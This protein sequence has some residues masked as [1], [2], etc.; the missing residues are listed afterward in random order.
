MPTTTDI[1]LSLGYKLNDKSVAGLGA[2][3]KLG[4]GSIQ[5][6]RFT[7]QGVGLRS[8]IDWKA[9]FGSHRGRKEASLFVSGGYELNYNSAFKNLHQLDDLNAWQTA[10]LI[11]IS[12]RLKIKTKF[13]KET[14]FQLLYDMLHKN[15]TPVTQPVIFRFGYQIK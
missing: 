13:I 8:F 12:K 1:G 10:G 7:H 14:K 9:P 11:G 5:H 15:H 3:Y 4:M 2:T 6:I